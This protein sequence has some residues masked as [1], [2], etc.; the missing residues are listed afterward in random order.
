MSNS[1]NTPMSP[2]MPPVTPPTP[3]TPAPPQPTP[4]Q[5]AP[6]IPQVDGYG[7]QSN[8][9]FYWNQNNGLCCKSDFNKCE[10]PKGFVCSPGELSNTK[11]QDPYSCIVPGQT[12][13]NM[14]N[15]CCQSLCVAPLL[16]YGSTNN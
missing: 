2:S 12:Y 10:T 9:G 7:C 16:R 1:S 3:P 6:V 5:P 13:D 4:P 14:S 11:T 15:K 8:L